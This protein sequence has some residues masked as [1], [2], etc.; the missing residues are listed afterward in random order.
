MGAQKLR[1]VKM[2]QK[3]SHLTYA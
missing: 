2:R 1:G 3:E